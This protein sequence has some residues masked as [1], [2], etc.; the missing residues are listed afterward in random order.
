[1]LQI[2]DNESFYMTFLRGTVGILSLDALELCA[3][4]DS[5]G[6]GSRGNGRIKGGISATMAGSG[7]ESGNTATGASGK[8]P[9]SEE[10]PS[11]IG[12]AQWERLNT[13][14]EKQV[15]IDHVLVAH[16]CA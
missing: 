1:M 6:D 7:S 13:T 10:E 8:G 5:G 11:L 15:H 12:E 16:V 2:E 14:L 9:S 3:Q 4:W